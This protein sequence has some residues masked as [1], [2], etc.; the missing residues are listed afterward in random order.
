MANPQGNNG[1]RQ[2]VTTGRNRR[3]LVQRRS[4]TKNRPRGYTQPRLKSEGGIIAPTQ[5]GTAIDVS[6]AIARMRA[7]RTRQVGELRTAEIG[8]PN[9]AQTGSGSGALASAANQIAT[10]TQNLA[11]LSGAAKSAG[12]GGGN[13]GGSGNKGSNR[14]SNGGGNG[15]NV[16]PN[17]NA[18]MQRMGLGY[19]A[20]PA[21]AERMFEI[22]A[23]RQGFSSRQTNMA[24]SIIEGGRGVSIP[25][26]NWRYN[27]DNPTSTAYGIPQAMGSLYGETTTNQWRNNVKPQLAWFLNYLQTHR[28]PTGVG[29][30]HAYR[31]KKRTNVY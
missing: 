30:A 16:G 22:M 10:N 18:F 8:T 23:K 14:G 7:M 5:P 29:V 26:S 28:Y 21:Q 20:T 6:K 2:G 24:R 1:P 25:E 15:V 4:K 3:S 19:H 12:G 31:Y 11:A 13:R 9:L 27:A 17:P